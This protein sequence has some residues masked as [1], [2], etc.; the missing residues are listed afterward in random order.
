M[1]SMELMQGIGWVSVCHCSE[2]LIT[3]GCKT[4]QEGAAS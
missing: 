1:L 3:P 2:A 4:H